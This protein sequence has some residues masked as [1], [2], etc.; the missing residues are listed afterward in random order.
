MN[1][2]KVELH[3][4]VEVVY[5]G[6][7]PRRSWMHKVCEKNNT[8]S[9]F[10]CTCF[11]VIPSQATAVVWEGKISSLIYW[12]LEMLTPTE[13]DRCSAVVQFGSGAEGQQGKETF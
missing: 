4:Q 3:Y 8:H 1:W 11:K 9:Q 12:L 6:W 2:K 13:D 10:T 5:T 7:G